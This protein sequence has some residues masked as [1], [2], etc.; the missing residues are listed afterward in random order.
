[1]SYEIPHSNAPLAQGYKL[2]ESDPKLSHAK[3]KE[4]FLGAQTRLRVSTKTLLHHLRTH[5]KNY[6]IA[7]VSTSL[8]AHFFTTASLLS[9]YQSV[10]EYEKAIGDIQQ[11]L[12]SSQ[13]RQAQITDVLKY[14]VSTN[15]PPVVAR[16]Q[17][18][19][20]AKESAPLVPETVTLRVKANLR[21][22]PGLHYE[23][24]MKLAAGSRLVVH[25]I[26]KGWY[27]VSTPTG[28]RL[29]VSDKV[30]K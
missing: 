13:K 22:G 30:I 7:L 23:P 15:T 18:K 9:A 28:E 4:F 24:Q 26:E 10:N 6:L 14:L 8:F 20:V 27:T 3:C 25:G 11:E 21:T 17:I 29:W 19:Q 1:M 5:P 2:C 16:P 12:K